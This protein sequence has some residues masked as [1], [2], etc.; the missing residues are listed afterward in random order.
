MES[1]IT[2]DCC[3]VTGT[4][5]DVSQCVNLTVYFI[6]IDQFRHESYGYL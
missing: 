2:S 3:D 5:H 6:L 1:E 4:R